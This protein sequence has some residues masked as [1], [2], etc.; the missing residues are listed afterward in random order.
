MSLVRIVCSREGRL[1]AGLLQRNNRLLAT[2]RRG[3]LGLTLEFR[4]E[5]LQRIMSVEFLE[6]PFNIGAEPFH[7][8][9]FVLPLKAG[10][11]I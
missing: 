8:A 3:F 5:S 2:E 10:S 6:E 7:W 4:G 1:K 9:N 11:D